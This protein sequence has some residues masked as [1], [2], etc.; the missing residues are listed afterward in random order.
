MQI[1][2]NRL[3]TLGILLP[4]APDR[5]GLYTY[6]KFFGNNLVYISGCG[7]D[8]PGK[9]PV[10]GKVGAD[11]SLAEGKLAAR[12]CVLNALAV[13][14]KGIGDLNR[15]ACFAKMLAFVASADDFYRQPEI[16]NGASEL[17]VEIF[18]E[19]VGCPARSAVGVNVL[20]GNI[21]VEVELLVALAD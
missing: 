9:P 4:P 15:V 5:A 6:C 12:H 10:V 8:M 16:A 20:P 17:L 7:P 13:L 2:A 18:G 11:V 1:I 14:E 19:A 3:Q 21:P